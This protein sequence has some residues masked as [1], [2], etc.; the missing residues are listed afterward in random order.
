MKN[1]LKLILAAAATALVAACVVETS[2]GG[3]I[4]VQP[5]TSPQP[6]VQPAPVFQSQ[7]IGTAPLCAAKPGDCGSLGS[8]WS[9]VR[10]D[11]AGNGAT[12]AT[13]R[14]VLCRRQIN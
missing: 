11:V 13:G 4:G 8:G 5:I 9:F 12:C 10:S 2:P 7:W 6:Q 14:K 3:S 1:I